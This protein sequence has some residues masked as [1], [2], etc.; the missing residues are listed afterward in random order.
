M[1]L[2]MMCDLSGYHEY[3]R[4]GEAFWHEGT[5]YQRREC[6]V[7]GVEQWR[8]VRALRLGEKS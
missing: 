7:C 8:E 5:R 1:T 4:W 3:L 6:K 2:P